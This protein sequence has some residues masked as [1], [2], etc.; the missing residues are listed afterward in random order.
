MLF[1]SVDA[2]EEPD[3]V[4]DRNGKLVSLAAPVAGVE[5]GEVGAELTPGSK[6]DPDRGPDLAGV[7]IGRRRDDNLVVRVVSVRLGTLEPH[8]GDTLHGLFAAAGNQDGGAVLA[9][10]L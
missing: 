2:V 6:I 5:D 4:A 1:R 8:M 10:H 7:G 3:L 9:L